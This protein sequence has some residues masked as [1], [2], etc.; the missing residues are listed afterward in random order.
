MNRMMLVFLGA[1]FFL[2]GSC[3]S[4]TV[5]YDGRGNVIGG[6]LFG[7]LNLANGS[8]LLLGQD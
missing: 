2:K 1:F 6:S 3:Q 5:I 8:F 7:L 4:T